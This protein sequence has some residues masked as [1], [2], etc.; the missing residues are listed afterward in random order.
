MRIVNCV[1]RAV[2]ERVA[3]LVVDVLDL[4]VHLVRR[5][6]ADLEAVRAGHV[7]ERRA[8]DV[9]LLI[10]GRRRIPAAI[11]E[12]RVG[13]T[14]RGALLGH[15]D[16]TRL[17]AGRNVAAPLAAERRDAGLEQQAARHR[18]RPRRLRDLLPF[19][20]HVAGLGRRRRGAER[21]P[22]VAAVAAPVAGVDER[23]PGAVRLVF[24]VEP[25]LVPRRELTGQADGFDLLGSPPT[26]LSRSDPSGSSTSRGSK[27]FA[28][29][30]TPGMSWLLP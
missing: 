16:E 20:P 14:G 4:P 8:P 29:A 22:V 15:G 3:Q 10:V 7:G 2:V 26:A 6:V 21:D 9:V 28:L 25:D 27:A 23:R 1:G 12:V 19:R 11:G 30:Y 13:N 24:V 18:R 5:L 17:R